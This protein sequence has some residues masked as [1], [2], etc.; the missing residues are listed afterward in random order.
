MTEAE[1][2]P[3]STGNE[4]PGPNPI[5]ESISPM[6]IIRKKCLDCS[7][8]QY[9]EVKACPVLRCPLW[10]FRLGIHPFVS[11]YKNDPMLN[12]ALWVGLENIPA[13]KAIKIVLQRAKGIQNNTEAR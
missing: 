1:Q 7:N 5:R 10:K 12:D 3:T 8:G 4:G 6:K 13:A 2:Q 9:I 11:K